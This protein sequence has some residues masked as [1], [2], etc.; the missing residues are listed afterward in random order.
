MG[1]A[2]S[3]LQTVHHRFASKH[4]MNERS[5]VICSQSNIVCSVHIYKYRQRSVGSNVDAR[6][7]LLSDG[8]APSHLQPRAANCQPNVDAN[9]VYVQC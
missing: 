5:D 2:A 7:P 1:S 3:R 6:D 8:L 4:S 9:S